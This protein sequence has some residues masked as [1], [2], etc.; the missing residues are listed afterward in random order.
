MT[1]QSQHME[2][3][4]SKFCASQNFGGVH[5][6]AVMASMPLVDDVE[7]DDRS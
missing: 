6:V 7:V 5:V 4:A 2:H 3:T 1:G